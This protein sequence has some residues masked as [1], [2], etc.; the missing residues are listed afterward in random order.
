[1]SMEGRKA[2]GGDVGDRVEE[3]HK[4]EGERRTSVHERAVS[5]PN[6]RSE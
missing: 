3:A 5:N 1:M 4:D 6:L 2:S